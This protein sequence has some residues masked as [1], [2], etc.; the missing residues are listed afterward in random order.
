MTTGQTQTMADPL[1]LAPT[2]AYSPWGEFAKRFRRNKPA[3]VSL[4]ILVGLGVTAA[5]FFGM[6]VTRHYWP[7]SPL[8]PD[9]LAK[10]QPPSR[11]QDQREVRQ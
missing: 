11:A 10:L 5:I 1:D 2:R 7:Y 8:S 3:M 9:L 4:G 6:E